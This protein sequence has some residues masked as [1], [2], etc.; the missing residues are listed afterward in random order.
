[1]RRRILESAL[2]SLVW[3][4]PLLV[5]PGALGDALHTGGVLAPLFLLAAGVFAGA[6]RGVRR[7]PIPLF[8]TAGVA[9]LWAW[10][11]GEGSGAV[12][13]YALSIVGSWLLVAPLLRTL[14]PVDALEGRFLVT[15]VADATA[16]LAS[17]SVAVLF[18]LRIALGGALA[19]ALALV[20]VR[21]PA[22]RERAG[23]A[24]MAGGLLHAWLGLPGLLE[25]SADLASTT[26]SLEDTLRRSAV[27]ASTV[28]LAAI[29]LSTGQGAERERR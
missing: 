18:D 23:V 28:A 9:E 27:L 19:V 14:E 8:A 4:G 1:M 6:R 11:A 26:V 16:I 21:Y 22:A 12:A 3:L 29:V 13:V 17:V 7:S 2:L 15:L 5:A 20:S 25:P 10:L 24:V